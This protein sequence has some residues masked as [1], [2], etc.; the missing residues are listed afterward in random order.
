MLDIDTISRQY[1]YCCASVIW[2]NKQV[3]KS[4]NDTLLKITCFILVIDSF[5]I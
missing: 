5:K 3:D 4:D 2:I 1:F